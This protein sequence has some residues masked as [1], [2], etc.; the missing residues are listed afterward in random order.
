MPATIEGRKIYLVTGTLS[1]TV[2]ICT[3]MNRQG[4]YQSVLRLRPPR[5]TLN[6]IDRHDTLADL[7]TFLQGLGAVDEGPREP[8]F[9]MATG[10]AA[11][12]EEAL[13][14]IWLEHATQTAVAAID[15]LI[16]DFAVHP[17]MHRRE[18]SWHA[19]LYSILA[20]NPIYSHLL[21]IGESG[22]YTQ[23]VHREW[24][25]NNGEDEEST[26]GRFDLAM[27]SAWQMLETTPERFDGGHITPAI[28]IEMGMDPKNPLEHLAT[29]H[30]HLVGSGVTEGFLVHLSRKSERNLDVEE[31][32]R[33]GSRRFQTAYA[34]HVDGV[35]T[36]KTLNGEVRRVRTT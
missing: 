9:A 19:R 27:F 1:Q 23:P 25:R 11:S 33:D 18:S 5:L 12:P 30:D 20:A 22:L 35:C 13:N 6:D 29:D 24:P 21:A 32:L 28:A 26:R 14:D 4:Y 3:G 10:V 31:Y 36:F 2:N 17:Y 34:H 16:W 7:G 15:A 8:S